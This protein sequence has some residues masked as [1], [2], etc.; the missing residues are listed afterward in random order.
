MTS[1][2][3]YKKVRFEGE[4]KEEETLFF[5][6]AHAIT[7]VSWVLTTV[8]LV[9]LPIVVLA[10]LFIVKTVNVPIS[11]L[12]TILILLVWYL[13]I[14]GVA[15]QQYLLWF[16]N[17]YILTNKRIVDIDFFGLFHRRVSQTTL[18]NVQDVTYSKSGILHNFLDYGDLR[19]QTAGTETHFDFINIPDPEGSQQQILDLVA[20]YRRGLSR[21]YGTSTSKVDK[22]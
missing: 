6:R 22:S 14:F 3:D 17:I 7:N 1:V 4:D 13:V 10:F 16:F 15:F 19:L 2:D 12:T 9:F 5:L 11:V 20:K 8:V 21:L 18:G